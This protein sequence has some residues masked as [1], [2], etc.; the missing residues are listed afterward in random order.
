MFQW[1]LCGVLIN[2]VS[3]EINRESGF[4]GCGGTQSCL[5][6]YG[7]IEMFSRVA[8]KPAQ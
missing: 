4:L 1:K 2:D 8:W 6:P 5:Q 7:L 3:A